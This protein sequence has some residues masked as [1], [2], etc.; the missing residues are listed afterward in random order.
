[1]NETSEILFT[2]MPGEKGDLGI[3]TLNRPQVL[4]ALNHAMFIALTQ[5]L[6]KW[7]DDSHIKAVV[8][9]AAAGRAFCAGGDIRYAYEQGL[10]KN[11]ELINFFGD[12]YK[13][14]KQIYH[15]PKPYI[16]MMDGIT[17]GGGVGLSIHG[18]HRVA[19]KRLIFAMPET[20]IGFFPDVGATYFLPR[21]KN[22]MGY[23]L[24][25]SGAKILYNDCLA[26]GLVDQ[27]VEEDSLLNI[28]NLL[29]STSLEKNADA[30][31]CEI[32]NNFAVTVEDSHL[33]QHKL[34]IE[35]CFSKATVED[36]ITAL[37]HYPDVWCQQV[38][39]ELKTK[40]PTS[41]KITLR[42]L[43]QGSK[44]NFD[45]CM[46]LEY[47]LTNRFIN[48][49]DFFEGVRAAIIDKDQ[50]PIWQPATLEDVNEAAIDNYFSVLE[51][52]LSS[53]V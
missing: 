34:A 30:V 38:A 16:A 8:I 20:A 9:R 50:N 45:E 12:E 28:I 53:S 52:E 46:D 43:Q 42:Q 5:Q 3:I 4:N 37:D 27:V 17:M 25:L 6:T 2:R 14:N 7:Q 51:K 49:H 31:V 11:P 15:F 29:A 24:G 18:S 26:L 40:S 19:T 48:N 47:R 1:M 13:L 32:I 41:L 35:K 33:V 22:K 21:L 44:L 36:I 39:N 23:Y 10:A